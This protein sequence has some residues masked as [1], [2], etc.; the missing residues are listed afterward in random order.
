MLTPKG[1]GFLG[2]PYDLPVLS[3]KGRLLQSGLR[4]KINGLSKLAQELLFDSYFYKEAMV[5]ARKIEANYDK[6]EP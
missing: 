2:F 1:D 6:N 3:A 4:K 5:G